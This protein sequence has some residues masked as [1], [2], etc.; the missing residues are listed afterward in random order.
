MTNGLSAL[1]YLVEI[2]Q[3]LVA[4]L[5]Y[6]VEIIVDAQAVYSLCLAVLT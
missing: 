6:L 5:L 3:Y 4:L 1:Q 2:L